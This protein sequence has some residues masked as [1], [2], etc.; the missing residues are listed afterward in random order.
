MCVA[1]G[2]KTVMAKVELVCCEEGIHLSINYE[3]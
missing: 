1:S 3:I 2:T